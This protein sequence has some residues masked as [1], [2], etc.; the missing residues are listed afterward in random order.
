[1]IA[2]TA[3]DDQHMLTRWPH[4][5]LCNGERLWADPRGEFLAAKGADPIYRLLVPTVWRP[6]M[7]GLEQRLPAASATTS[8]R[9]SA[10]TEYDG[11]GTW[12]ADRHLGR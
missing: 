2:S 1:M 9:A 4:D 5:G 6:T 8:A 12:F 7:P 3:A 10:V 11:S